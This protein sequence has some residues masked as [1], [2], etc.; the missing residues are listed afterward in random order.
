VRT[1][2]A[3]LAVKLWQGANPTA[4]DFR[5]DSVGEGAFTASPLAREADGSWVARV[6][7]PPSGFTAW[8]VELVLPGG[9]RYP[10]KFTTEVQVTPDVLPYR[11]EDARPITAPE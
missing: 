8:F 9:G 7:A 1:Q 5:V 10:H 11:W 2:T 3:P 6:G 4:R